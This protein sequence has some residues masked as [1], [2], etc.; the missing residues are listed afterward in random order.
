MADCA[1]KGVAG[2][3]GR[4]KEKEKITLLLV[5]VPGPGLEP[6]WVA[7]SVFETDASTD[8]AIRAFASTKLGIIL[9]SAKFFD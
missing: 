4:A 6:G 1:A 8:S 5:L 9:H 3:F 2:A 7:P